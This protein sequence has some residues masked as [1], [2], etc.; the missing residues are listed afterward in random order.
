MLYTRISSIILSFSVLLIIS[1]S[2]DKESD[3]LSSFTQK[4]PK[5]NFADFIG[6]N[7]C[8][9]CHADIY[10]QWKGSSHANAGGPA[11]PENVIAP[12]D[13]KPIELYLSLIHI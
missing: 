4:D 1:C 7:Q 9:A 6:S 11:S 8:Q 3:Q 13:G 5:I 2:S 12:F 10:D